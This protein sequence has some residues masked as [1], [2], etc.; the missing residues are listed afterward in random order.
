MY[1]FIYL[2]G[3]QISTY[4]VMAVIGLL[5]TGFFFCK[6]IKKRGLDDNEGIIFL[7][8]SCIGI[9]LGAKILYALTNIDKFF[10]ITKVKTIKDFFT[11]MSIL[12]GGGVF[13]GGLLGGCL[14]GVIYVKI[15]KLPF[16]I[17]ADTA[18]VSIPLFHS[19]ARLGCFLGGCCYGIESSFGFIASNNNFTDIGTVRRF[20]VQVLESIINLLIFLFLLYLLKKKI[21]EGKLLYIYLLLYAVARFLLEYLRGDEIRGFVL[22]LSTSQFISVVIVLILLVMF[23]YKKIK[24]FSK[25]S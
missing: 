10:L 2:F 9:L 7:L 5:V 4:T 16:S 17:Y 25:T 13:Y 23:F 1:P 19:I 11:F 24:N 21:L 20:P 15:R 18:A 12:F 22:G 14:A 8:I 6:L 3:K